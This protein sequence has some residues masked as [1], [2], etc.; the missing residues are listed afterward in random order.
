[1]QNHRAKMATS[2]PKGMA[3]DEPSPHRIRFIKKKSAN[4]TLWEEKSVKLPHYKQMTTH[5]LDL[6][7]ILV[8]NQSNMKCRHI[9]QNDKT[10]PGQRNAVSSTLVFHFSPPNAAHNK[11]TDVRISNM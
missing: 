11:H 4:T 8:I 10:H 7:C 2:V 3:A 1:M 6:K 9:K 5:D